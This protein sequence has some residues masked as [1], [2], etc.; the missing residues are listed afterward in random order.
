MHPALVIARKDLRQR[1]RDRSAIVL[2]F[3]APIAI[4]WLMSL[5]F[6]SAFEFHAN[7]GYVDAD[8]GPLATAFHDMLAGRDLSDVVSL[9]TYPDEAAARRAV[10]DRTIDT[11][12]VVPAG[13]TESVHGG[14]AVTVT[15]LGSADKPLATQVSRS[16]AE[17]FVAQVNA[18]RLS[19]GAAIAAGAPADRVGEL[20]RASARLHLPV[21]VRQASSRANSLQAL[22]YYAPSMGIFFVL[23]AVSFGARGWFVERAAGTLDRIAAAPIGLG[24][25]LVGK[26]LSTFVYAVASLTTMAVF[27]SLVLGAQ[28]GNPLAVALL[29]VATAIAV[30]ALTT[31]VTAVAR[32]ERQAEGLSSIVVFA[33]ALA[34]GNFVFLS[35][36]P[37]LLRRLALFTPNGW[38]LRGFTDLA[39]GVSAATAVVRPVL[40]IVAFSAALSVVTAVLTRRLVRR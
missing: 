1:L 6:G 28:W 30:V 11:A 40:G 15:V 14:R 34:G 27:S 33:L 21:E 5:A 19:V 23:F 22:S 31:F 20:A 4:A 36:A 26:A 2:G 16:L 35:V 32:T 25:V 39:S 13:F 12:V 10:D 37:P 38:A 18:D 24:T 29:V 3:I 17:S 7:V 9:R 8:R